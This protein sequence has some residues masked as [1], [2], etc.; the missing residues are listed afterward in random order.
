MATAPAPKRGEIWLID[1]DPA[2][3]AE[4]NKLRPA[5]VINVDTIGRLPLRMV[6]PITDWKPHYARY[7]WF[8]EL[9]ATPANGLAKDSGVDA[10][11]T[12]SISL[13]R[14]VRQLGHVTADQLDEI[15]SAVALCVGAT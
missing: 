13:R 1:F 6:V 2:A 10:F 8:V 4:I 12:K 7:P 5:V 11:Q 15:A 9:L 14:F 3:G